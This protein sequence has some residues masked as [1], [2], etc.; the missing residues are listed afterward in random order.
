MPAHVFAKKPKFCLAIK[1]AVIWVRCITCGRPHPEYLGP[2]DRD[3][4]EAELRFL[5][6]EVQRLGAILHAQNEQNRKKPRRRRS[7]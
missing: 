5:R 6:A 3:D 2:R 7:R 4:K 1:P